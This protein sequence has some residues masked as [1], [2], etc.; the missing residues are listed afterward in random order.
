MQV[1]D[2]KFE[3]LIKEKIGKSYRK[4]ADE[5][6]NGVTADK[7]REEVGYLRGLRDALDLVEKARAELL[8]SR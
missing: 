5:V 7:Y 6:I 1:L 4:K 3:Q 2:S 8:Q